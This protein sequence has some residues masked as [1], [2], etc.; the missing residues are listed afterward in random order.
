MFAPVSNSSTATLRH[1]VEPR[2]KPV[3]TAVDLG[4]FLARKLAHRR[5]IAV[6]PSYRLGDPEAG[7]S[8]LVRRIGDIAA[9]A[10]D[11]RIDQSLNVN[12]F[13]HLHVSLESQVF[14]QLG[15]L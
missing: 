12:R 10:L 6:R 8:T 15:T 4:R 7:G 2:P 1:F 9:L 3:K 14:N 13:I 11:Q 5:A